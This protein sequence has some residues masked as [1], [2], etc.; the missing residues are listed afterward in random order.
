MIL[1]ASVNGGAQYGPQYVIILLMGTLG[2]PHFG[3][4]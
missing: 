3:E 1:L 2:S 4:P